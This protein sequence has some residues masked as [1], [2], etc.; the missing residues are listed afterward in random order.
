MKSHIFG[1]Q[2]GQETTWI[3][4]GVDLGHPRGVKRRAAEGLKRGYVEMI[5]RCEVEVKLSWVLVWK[6]GVERVAERVPP[7]RALEGRG[8]P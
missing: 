3:D 5:L 1:E 4:F 6:G 2:G 8:D 7:R